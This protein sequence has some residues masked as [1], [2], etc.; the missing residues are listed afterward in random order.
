MRPGPP[1]SDPLLWTFSFVCYECG[2]P[3]KSSAALNHH[4]RRMHNLKLAGSCFASQD[5]ICPVCNTLFWTRPRLIRHLNHSSP[6]CLEWLQNHDHDFSVSQEEIESFD[7]ADRCARAALT[8]QGRRD[9][10]AL[11]PSCRLQGPLV[12][13]S[14]PPGQVQQE[15]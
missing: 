9:L 12:R 5:G 13:F 6:R 7:A 1:R 8:S 3:A 10:H 11:R 14:S 4:Q 2:F 15:G